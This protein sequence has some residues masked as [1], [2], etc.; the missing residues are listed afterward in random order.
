MAHVSEREF[1]LYQDVVV[2]GY[3]FHDMMLGRLLELAGPDATVILLSDHGFHSGTLR[4][5]EIPNVP[6]GP[7]VEHRQYGVLCM[8]GPGIRT[9]ERVFGA[10]LLNIAPTVLTLL[11]L[12]VGADMA[13]PLVQAFESLPKIET[14]PSW[15]EVP[16]EAGLHDGDMQLDPWAEQEALQQLVELGYI[17]APGE[18]AAAAAEDARLHGAFNLGRVYFSTGR[19]ALAVPL[20]EQMAAVE[21]E[22]AAYYGLWLAQAYVATGDLD[23]AWATVERVRALPDAATGALDLLTVDLLIARGDVD[24]ALDLL[25]SDAVPRT[26]DMWLRRGEIL[27]RQQFPDDAEDA[28]RHALSLDPDEARAH[29]GLAKVHIQRHEYQQ[30]ADAALVAIGHLYFYPEAHFHLGVAV[31]RLGWA[32]RAAQAFEVALQQRPGLAQARR[33]LARVY[34]EYLRQPERAQQVL[35]EGPRAA[36]IP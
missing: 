17:E 13:P 19:A 7:A 5:T 32:E 25:A 27:L 8:A 12:P 9:D 1:A 10:G 26:V 31:L 20:F 6:G 21:S 33:W 36:P 28:F 16:G 29:H 24:A 11:G 22:H 23:R 4:P 3:R 18:D 30:A 14:V 2:A 35:A 15:E 34:H